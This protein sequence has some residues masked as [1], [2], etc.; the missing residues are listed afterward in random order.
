[1]LPTITLPVTTSSV[2]HPTI[3]DWLTAIG[4]V[5][6]LLIAAAAAIVAFRQ[7]REARQLREDQAQPFV[8]V[9][10]EPSAVSRHFINL[11]IRN[12]GR[13]LARD[14]TIKFKPPIESTIDS[15][16]EGICLRTRRGLTSY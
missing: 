7:L 10:V 11:I 8:I 1:V 4:T 9:D 15:I 2:N 12:T 6:T 3:T 14:A 13:T 5:G 16:R